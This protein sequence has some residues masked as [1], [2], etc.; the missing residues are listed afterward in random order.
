VS[1]I[2]VAARSCTVARFSRR[3]VLFEEL[4]VR[5]C[6]SFGYRCARR[7]G[8]I[9]RSGIRREGIGRSDRLPRSCSAGRASDH[10]DQ[11]EQTLHADTTRSSRCGS[12]RLRGNHSVT[13]VVDRA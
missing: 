12:H 1:G 8:R 4:G 5:R 13:R 9:R 10:G 2:R 3:K 6:V 11:S 7:C